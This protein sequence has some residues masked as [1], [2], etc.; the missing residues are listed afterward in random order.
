MEPSER[1]GLRIYALIKQRMRTAHNRHIDTGRH[2]PYAKWRDESEFATDLCAWI[3]SLDVRDLPPR[4]AKAA[5]DFNVSTRT[6][7][8]YLERCAL[9]SWDEFLGLWAEAI[10]TE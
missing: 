3:D 10:R 7:D 5:R 6:I 1:R 4:L 9:D 2:N 8:R